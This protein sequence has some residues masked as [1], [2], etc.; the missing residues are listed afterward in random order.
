M[1]VCLIIEQLE[2]L[3]GKP[4]TMLLIN[5]DVLFQSPFPATKAPEILFYRIKQ[6]QEIQTITQDPYMPKQMI[7]NAVR[8]LMQS[9]I[10]PLKEFNVW[11]ATP[12]KSY[13]SLKTFIH[14]AYPRRLM[15]MQLRNMVGQQ[16][17]VQQNIYNNLDVD[18]NE[19][20]DD[21]TTVTLPAVA[22]AM[23]TAGNT[24]GSTYAATTVLTIAAKVTAAIVG[25]SNG[26]HA[27]VSC[28]EH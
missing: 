3:Y 10:F 16:G 17:Y 27:A 2:T 24:I 6:C 13:P 7:G 25:Q 20:T 21:K 1:S 23:G 28:H 4:N 8:L 11:E 15:A 12:V 14:E 5:N 18:S 19:D 26:H 9:G 22:A